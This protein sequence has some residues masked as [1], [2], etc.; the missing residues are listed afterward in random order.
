MKKSKEEFIPSV[1]VAP[2]FKLG[3]VIFCFIDY[4]LLYKYR[5]D[6]VEAEMFKKIFGQSLPSFMEYLYP[7]E[8]YI[9]PLWIYH[10]DAPDR[11]NQ[12]AYFNTPEWRYPIMTNEIELKHPFE[13]I[14]CEN[15]HLNVT[16]FNYIEGEICYTDVVCIDCGMTLS[17]YEKKGIRD[18]AN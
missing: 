5:N 13:K 17:S 11:I 15:N 3:R 6:I 4:D 2:L 8:L 14:V 10:I 12:Y 9:T 1:R 7:V 18:S 16:E